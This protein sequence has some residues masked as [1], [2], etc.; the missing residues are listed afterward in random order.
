MKRVSLRNKMAL[1]ALSCTFGFGAHAQIVDATNS[2]PCDAHVRFYALD[3]SSCAVVAFDQ[4]VYT[5][6]AGTV[7]SF[8]ITIS[9]S[10]PPTVTYTV[11]TEAADAA[12]GF[13]GTKVSAPICTYAPAG[14]LPACPA[15]APSYVD[16]P[17][18]NFPPGPSTMHFPLSIHL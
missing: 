18:P 3:I 10:M 7:T 17:P 9:W 4:A 1:L 12:C 11:I 8:P 6:P 15:C 16:A 2:T 13:P 14:T 5:I